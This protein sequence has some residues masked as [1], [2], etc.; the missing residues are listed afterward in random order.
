MEP[1]DAMGRPIREYEEPP[2]RVVQGFFVGVLLQVLS[3]P[4][5]FV[6]Y[7]F[8]GDN[9]VLYVYLLIGIAQLV[10]MGPAIAMAFRK[11]YP[12]FGKGLVIAAAL[13][14]LLNGACWG[15][16]TIYLP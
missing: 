16:A 5:A 6:V 1:R 7:L 4:L 12:K 13:V 11:G 8:G 3:F 2:S 9:S 10:Y 15:F 14:A